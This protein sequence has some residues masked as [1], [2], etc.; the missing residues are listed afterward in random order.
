MRKTSRLPVFASLLAACVSSAA[1]TLPAFSAA[2]VP[3]SPPTAA[4]SAATPGTPETF[5]YTI[6]TI[7]TD[8]IRFNGTGYPII[9]PDVEKLIDKREEIWERMSEDAFKKAMPEVERWAAKGRPYVK[10]ARQPSDLLKAEI[11]AFPGA[12]GGGMYTLGGRGGKVFVVTSLADHGPGTFREACEAGGPRIV[13]FNVAGVI[14]LE[15]PLTIYAPYISIEGQTAPGDGVCIAGQTTH[16]NTHDIVIRYMRFRR[17]IHDITSRDDSLSGDSIGNVMLDHISASWGNDE[18]FSNYRQMYVAD[19]ANPK[20]REKLPVINITIQWSLITETLDTYH[21]GFGGTWGGLNTAFHHNMFACCT[22]RNASIGM[23]FD[24]NFV[25][26]VLF[27]WRHRTLDGGDQSSRVNVINNYFR[28][29]PKTELMKMARADKGKW[30]VNGNIWHGDPQISA[31]N[32]NGGV[33]ARGDLRVNEPMPMPTI[34]VQSAQDAFASVLASS[35]ATLP[36]RDA[37]D[38]RAVRQARTGEVD[39]KEGKGIITDI[40]QVGGFPSY[41]GEPVKYS[42]NDGIPDWWKQKYHLDLQDAS[43][44]SRDADGDGYTTVEEYLNGTDPTVKVDYRDLKNNS[45][46][47]ATDA[48]SRL[49]RNQ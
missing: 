7:P 19:P 30:Y 8:R 16:L 9:P 37:V 10:V 43:L 35:G 44:A 23:G 22:G 29:G 39:Y 25:N 31:D 32:W 20:K 47:L 18:T 11:P 5:D 17:G 24:F 26:N 6:P 3:Q 40:S 1:L 2:P 12:E 21:H 46:P 14:H 38:Q 33:Q 45:N 41:Q 13:V 28:P 42:L 36:V 48:A 34:T 27:N 49:L 4:A 15:R